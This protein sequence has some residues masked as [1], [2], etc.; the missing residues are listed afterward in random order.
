MQGI[1]PLWLGDISQ[2]L[3]DP[4]QPIR[5]AGHVQHGRWEHN[6]AGWNER[7]DRQK[8]ID[9]ALPF[10]IAVRRR[11]RGVVG[12][13]S[14]VLYTGLVRRIE[15]RIGSAT[16]QGC[17]GGGAQRPPTWNASTRGG[18]F[19]GEGTRHQATR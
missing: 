11:L 16:A 9:Q 12:A 8:V 2:L 3:P 17:E 1:R 15:R 7:V 18:W 4:I 13:G 5:R 10:V 14:R 6:A 19:P